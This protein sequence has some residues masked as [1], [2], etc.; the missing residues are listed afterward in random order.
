MLAARSDS[1]ELPVSS[2]H[3]TLTPK[4]FGP[5]PIMAIWAIWPYPTSENSTS[6]PKNTSLGL[7]QQDRVVPKLSRNLC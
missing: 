5:N 2:S 6:G 7:C 1:V 4:S 3:L